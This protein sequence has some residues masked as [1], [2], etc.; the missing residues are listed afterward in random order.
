MATVTGPMEY[1]TN[2]VCFSLQRLFRYCEMFWE[3]RQQ[4]RRKTQNI[5]LFSSLFQT[6]S[7]WNIINDTM[8]QKRNKETW[9]QNRRKHLK[10]ETTVKLVY[11]FISCLV[12][13]VTFF[14]LIMYILCTHKS[15]FFFFIATKES[16]RRAV[17]GFL[18]FLQSI[19]PRMVLV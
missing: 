12:Q 19:I 15:L 18:R 3:L 4:R 14:R 13:T 5:D 16:S 7:L 11:V 2:F 1:Q 9:S 8:M 17:A 10:I 6:G